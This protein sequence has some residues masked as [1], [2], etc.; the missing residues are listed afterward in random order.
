[1]RIL[2][3]EDFPRPIVESLRK[4]GHDVVWARTD[5]PGLRDRAL[6]ERAEADG[7]VVLTLDKDFWQI[8]LQRPIPL[9]RCGVILFRT[10]PAVPEH[11]KPLVDSTLRAEQS[12]VGHVTI[13]TND[14]IEMIPA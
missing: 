14:G 2:A 1:M 5:C 11:V 10:F 3:D 7:R 13:V 6:L 8:A 9:K 12:G 4:Q